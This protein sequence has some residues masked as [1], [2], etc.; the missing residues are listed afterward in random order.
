MP[1]SNNNTSGQGSGMG[2]GRGGGKNRM[3]GN[4]PGSGPAGNCVCPSCGQKLPHQT[5]QPCFNMTCPNCGSNMI[6]E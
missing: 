1:F 5:G 3:G 6:K 4:R 2:R